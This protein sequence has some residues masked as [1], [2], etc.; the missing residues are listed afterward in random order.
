MGSVCLSLSLG[1]APRPVPSRAATA[2]KAIAKRQGAVRHMSAKHGIAKCMLKSVKHCRKA[3]VYKR[4]ESVNGKAPYVWDGDILCTAR[5]KT[6]R[7]S[8]FKS[9]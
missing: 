4:K 7:A 5:P 3:V 2:C 9:Y 8:E 1:T 6:F